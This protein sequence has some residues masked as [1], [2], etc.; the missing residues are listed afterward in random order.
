M[1][2]ECN[3]RKSI[4][5]RKLRRAANLQKTWAVDNFN[6]ANKFN[7]D[8]RERVSNVYFSTV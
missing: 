6:I 2:L 3:G 1:S 5:F 4:A 7:C 8:Y